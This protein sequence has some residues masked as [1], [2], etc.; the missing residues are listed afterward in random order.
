[1][2]KR[3]SVVELRDVIQRLKLGQGIRRIHEQTGIHR[4]IIRSVRDTAEAA[5]W[6]RGEAELPNEEQIQGV[7]RK[8]VSAEAAQNPLEAFREDF[9]RWIEAG[10]SYVVMHQLIKDRCQ[11]SEATLRRVRAEEI[12]PAS[13]GELGADYDAGG[14]DGGGFRLPGNQLRP[15]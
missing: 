13:T 8:E 1:M 14:G 3:R 2:P 5:G 6:L 7:R 12:P 9:Q 11:C 4:T 15:P 10:H